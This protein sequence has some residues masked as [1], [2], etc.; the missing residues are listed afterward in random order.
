MVEGVIELATELHL[1]PFREPEGLVDAEVEV[2]LAGHAEGV[3]LGHRLGERPEVGD[4]DKGVHV[5]IVKQFDRGGCWIPSGIEV[6][7]KRPVDERIDSRFRAWGRT[8][9]NTSRDSCPERGKASRAS[10]VDSVHAYLERIRAVVDREWSTRLSCKNRSNLPAI[11]NL[12][13][14]T[15]CMLAEWDVPDRL[16]GKAFPDVQIRVAVVYPRVERIQVAEVKL[17]S[18]RTERIA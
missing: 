3:S 12:L 11:Q 9:R 5:G 10:C 7:P 15:M 2:P 1:K 16:Q 13:C 4:T 6:R 17:V 8:C 18:R 14:Y